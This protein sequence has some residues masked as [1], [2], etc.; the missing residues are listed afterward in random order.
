MNPEIQKIFEIF[1]NNEIY[2]VGGYVR[3]YLLN[4]KS[5]DV[6]FTTPLLPE[7]VIDILKEN[8]LK[9]WE[10]GKTFGTISTQIN[11][12]KIEITTYRIDEKYEKN[13]RKP[14]V[15][16][17]KSL[18]DDLKRRDFTINT[19]AMDKD[20]KIIDYFNGQD[21]LINKILRTPLDSNS[22]FS[23]DPLRM[24]RAIRFA[25]QLGFGID[26]VTY[27]SI[28]ENAYKILN[29]AVERIKPEME[30]LLLG[31][32]VIE[33]LNLLLGS[34]LL[35][36]YIPELTVLTNIKQNPNY[37]HKDVWNHTVLVV[38][39]CPK[40]IL[41][42]WTAL[43]HD[44]AKPYVKNIINNEIHFYNH[45]HLGGKITEG[46]LKRLKF[47]NKEIETIITLIKNH[48]RINL[49][50]S[51]W[52]TKA[53]RKLKSDLGENLEKLIKLSIADCTSSKKE[54][55]EDVKAKINHL[56]KRLETPIIKQDY[57][58]PL[59]GHDIIEN[60]DITQ[61]KIVG[62]LK[63]AL[64]TAIDNGLLPIKHYNKKIYINYLKEYLNN[65]I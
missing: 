1:K 32:S 50:T 63:E 13:N 38:K 5:D 49:Y 22:T 26:V 25:S 31:K 35:N 12:K 46:I 34:K 8:N 54:R 45:E 15:K 61:G 33:G 60:L 2:L 19:L 56:Q 52:T 42:K 16:F 48:M 65:I 17:G 9:Y 21:D 51:D 62:Q 36:F 57:P 41:L 3:D 53:I 4:R 27:T 47:S 20:G 37:H 18:K 29:V 44:I 58:L 30:K 64:K 23:D 40:D 39:N 24:F 28:K 43:F 6:D 55:Q 14:R 7:Q 11:K 10:I 59:T